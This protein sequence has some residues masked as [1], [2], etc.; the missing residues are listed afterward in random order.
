M[1][2]TPL[3]T[4]EIFTL[5]KEVRALDFSY[6]QIAEACGGLD[7][8]QVF[9]WD[10]GFR[11]VPDKYRSVL[12]A[13]V[14]KGEP[15]PNRLGQRHHV[16]DEVKDLLLSLM[17]RLGRPAVAVELGVDRSTTQ[18]WATGKRQV[19]VRWTEPVLE[20]ARTTYR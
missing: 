15:A 13:I 2:Q 6:R 12:E 20:L 18:R 9:Q 7:P 14:H 5:F 10:R 3:H 16:S 17:N 11:P 1:T 8:A 19:P 4:P